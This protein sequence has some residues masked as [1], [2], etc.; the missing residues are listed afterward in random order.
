[1]EPSN[2]ATKEKF[3]GI[4]D[5]TK[6]F[7][8][9]KDLKT[10]KLAPYLE[11]R[12]SKI[13]V[14]HLLLR[15]EGQLGY[16][17]SQHSGPIPK[18]HAVLK[19]EFENTSGYFKGVRINMEVDMKVRHYLGSAGRELQPGSLIFQLLPYVGESRS[20]ACTAELFLLEKQAGKINFTLD[21]L[22]KPLTNLQMY[23]FGFDTI[24]AS[25]Y[26]CRDWV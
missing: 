18:N 23:R 10:Q 5:L 20:S 9:G 25:F 17:P 26:G 14:E 2:N 1:M 16:V 6:I 13:F 12:C 11:M 8:D 24:G 4:F 3:E 19:I 22:L 15:P 21:E 7:K